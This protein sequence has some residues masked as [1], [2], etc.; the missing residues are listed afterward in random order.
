MLAALSAAVLVGWVSGV[1]PFATDAPSMKPLVA[2]SFLLL[3]FAFLV[4]DDEAQDTLPARVVGGL[5]AL[6]GV[7][8]LILPHVGDHL[9][10]WYPGPLTAMMLGLLGGGLLLHGRRLGLFALPSGLG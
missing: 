6:V 10:L 3:A 7:A 5:L 9:P 8:F 4:F 2:S 1:Y